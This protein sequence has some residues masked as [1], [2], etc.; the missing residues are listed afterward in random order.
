M[1]ELIEVHGHQRS[2]VETVAQSL[3]AKGYTVLSVAPFA[4]GRGY[5]IAARQPAAHQPLG[6]NLQKGLRLAVCRLLAWREVSSPE[7]AALLALAEG[8]ESVHNM[9]LIESALARLGK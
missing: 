7:V 6:S 1:I 3:E 9:D 5:L 4:Q 2:F 8:H